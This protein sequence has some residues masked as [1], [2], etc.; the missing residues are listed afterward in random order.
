[1]VRCDCCTGKKTI[2]GLGNIAK[3]CPACKGVGVKQCDDLA[4]ASVDQPCEGK[5][6]L[7]STKTGLLVSADIVDLVSNKNNDSLPSLE[8]KKMLQ[9]AK[10]KE[11][12]AKRKAKEA[13]Q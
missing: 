4:N 7:H 2:V 5:Y 8:Q 10:M 6:E 11:V 9:S 3:K 1:M 13:Q 12:W